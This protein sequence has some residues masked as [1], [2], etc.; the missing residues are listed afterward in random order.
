MDPCFIKPLD[1]DFILKEL[2]RYKNILIVEE[3]V[4]AGGFGS[5]VLELVNEHKITD[6]NIKRMGLPDHFIEHGS[7]SLLRDLYSLNA[8]GIK[9]AGLELLQKSV[10]ISWRYPMATKKDWIYYW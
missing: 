2:A 5:A 4:L 1:E 9:T 6:L 8:R 7:Q 3:Q 10:M